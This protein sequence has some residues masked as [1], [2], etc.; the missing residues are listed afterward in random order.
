[1][2]SKRTLVTI[3]ALLISSLAAGCIDPG[4]GTV[5]LIITEDEPSEEFQ[6]FSATFGNTQ[7]HRPQEDDGGGAFGVENDPEWVNVMV[8]PKSFILFQANET[9]APET[10]F[11]A[12]VDTGPYNQV[13]VTVEDA[14][15][16]TEDGETVDIDT[17]AGL[18]IRAN[19]TVDSGETTTLLTVLDTDESLVRTDGRWAFTPTVE[20]VEVR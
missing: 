1:M 4:V 13:L 11:E 2:P 6:W 12:G 15:G 14:E 8:Q 7:L 19:F 10:V 20:R 18:R 5:K 9:S 3:T 17:S 16:L